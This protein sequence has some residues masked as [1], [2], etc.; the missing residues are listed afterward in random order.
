MTTTSRHKITI[1]PLKLDRRGQPYSVSFEGDTIIPKTYNPSHDACRSLTEQGYHGALEVWSDGET[2]PRM[3]I[4]DI[5]RAAKFTVS[6]TKTHG[7]RVVRYKP[8][9]RSVFSRE[10]QEPV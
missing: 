5:E 3:I 1:H 9:D 10:A 4:N 8:L 6:E 2:H 7:P